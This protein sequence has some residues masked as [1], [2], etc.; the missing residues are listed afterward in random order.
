MPVSPNKV[1]DQLAEL[2]RTDRKRLL[3]AIRE[4]DSGQEQTSRRGA[5]SARRLLDHVRSAHNLLER[6]PLRLE[7]VIDLFSRLEA[8]ETDVHLGRFEG[9]G[10]FSAIVDRLTDVR[11]HLE[12][13][14][15]L[16]ESP[17]RLE[18]RQWIDLTQLRRNDE[19]DLAE[20]LMSSLAQSFAG[21]NERGFD[22][23]VDIRRLESLL[24]TTLA[25]LQTTMIQAG[26]LED[27]ATQTTKVEEAIANAPDDD[28]HIPSGVRLFLKENGG[29]IATV[30]AAIIALAG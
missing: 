28:P 14:V 26:L 12:L 20:R 2:V 1:R 7:E 19:L 5:A 6:W 13:V 18:R 3:I 11:S 23:D 24:K 17:D 16:A 27:L 15:A 4:F 10:D 25:A 29:A 8:I 21:D 9:I 30:I 22:Y